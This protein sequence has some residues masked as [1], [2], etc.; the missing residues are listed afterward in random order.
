MT[1]VDGKGAYLVERGTDGSAVET[2]IDP[3]RL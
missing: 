2:R 1:E 3:R